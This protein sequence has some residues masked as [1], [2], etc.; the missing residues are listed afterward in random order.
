MIQTILSITTSRSWPIHQL[1]VKNEFLHRHLMETATRV[2][3]QQFASFLRQLGFIAS[4]FDTYKEGPSIAYLLLYVDDIVLITSSLTLLQHIMGHLHS[5]F[6]MMDLGDLHHFLGIFIIHS[7]QGLFL[8]QRQ[9]ALDLL[10]RAGM[11][12]CH[13]IATPV[14]THAKLSVCLFMH[15]LC[16]PR[17]ALIKRILCYVKGTL[18]SGLHIIIGPV[19]SLTAYSDANWACCPNS[20]RSISSFS[21]YLSDNL[22]S[23]SSKCQSTVSHSNAEVEYRAVA[24]AAAYYCWLRQLHQELHVPL[25]SA[26]V[27]YYDNVSAVYMTTN[28]VH[29]WC[30]K[31]IEID[32][33]F[34]RE[35]VALGEVW[36]LHVP[37]SHQ[38]ADI[39]MKGLPTPLFTEF[40]SNM[41]VC[42]P[43]TWTAGKY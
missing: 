42:D 5:E 28:P 26:T 8:S 24:P 39:M 29:H 10:K 14:D 7:T 1:N 33:H 25:A 22:L 6:A 15:D 3:Y 37:S 36:V 12:E 31:H 21:I 9:S 43:P 18:S 38:F 27:V 40:R 34:A 20:R 41:C 30:T 2:W 13:S 17:M 11:A 16:E 4:T 32:I 23:W 35:K 19:Q